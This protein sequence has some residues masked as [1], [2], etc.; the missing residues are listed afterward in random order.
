VR[1]GVLSAGAEAHATDD[2]AYLADLVKLAGFAPDPLAEAAMLQMV[3]APRE[4]VFKL[5]DSWKHSPRRGLAFWIW[6]QS[7]AARQVWPEIGSPTRSVGSE[8]AEIDDEGKTG[9]NGLPDDN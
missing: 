9:I 7:Q 2:S 6:S 1:V 3:R 5:A 4:A 8:D